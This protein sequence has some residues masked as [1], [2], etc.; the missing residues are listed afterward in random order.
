MAGFVFAPENKTNG[1][2]AISCSLAP[3]ASAGKLAPAHFA[4]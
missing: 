3:R 1:L 2:G 4:F